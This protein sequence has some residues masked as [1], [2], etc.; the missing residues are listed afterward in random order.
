M[1]KDQC[2]FQKKLCVDT[3]L[4]FKY[5]AMKLWFQTYTLILMLAVAI[6]RLNIFPKKINDWFNALKNTVVWIS[7]QHTK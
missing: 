6:V 5:F 4:V 2:T 3:T 7:N 1:K